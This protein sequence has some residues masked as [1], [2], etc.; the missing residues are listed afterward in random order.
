MQ[1]TNENHDGPT[2]DEMCPWTKLGTSRRLPPREGGYE[3]VVKC[4]IH[5]HPRQ[6]SDLLICVKLFLLMHSHK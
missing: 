5:I 4:W 6:L 3:K 2:H 1:T